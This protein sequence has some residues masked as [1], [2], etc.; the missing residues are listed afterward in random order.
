MTD[1]V[2]FLNRSVALIV[3]RGVSSARFIIFPSR[4]DNANMCENVVPKLKK[5][6]NNKTGSDIDPIPI[7]MLVDSGKTAFL[8]RKIACILILIDR[9]IVA[10]SVKKS[11]RRGAI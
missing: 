5:W 7:L 11:G 10:R 6:Q 3:N 1:P 4:K 2:I 9:A 8:L